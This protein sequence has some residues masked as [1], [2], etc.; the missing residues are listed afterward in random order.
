MQQTF[1]IHAR[2]SGYITVPMRGTGFVL[3][4]AVLMSALVTILN[5]LGTM[6]ATLHLSAVVKS[7][8]LSPMIRTAGPRGNTHKRDIV[9]RNVL[10]HPIEYLLS[11]FLT[12]SRSTSTIAYKL[13]GSELPWNMCRYS[14]RLICWRTLKT[15]QSQGDSARSRK[16][17]IST[18]GRTIKGAERIR[19]CLGDVLKEPDVPMKNTR[20][21]D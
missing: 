18:C 2:K 6:P 8:L 9:V 10:T 21:R 16:C 11:T 7:L 14:E 13:P 1:S 3:P 19:R 5:E 15:L 12:G 4:S 17:S 20:G